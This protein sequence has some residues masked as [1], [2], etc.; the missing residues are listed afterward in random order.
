[1]L[2]RQHA[3]TLLWALALL[4]CPARL[5]A[6]VVVTVP[7]ELHL[8]LASSQFVWYGRLRG[9]ASINAPAV[10][11]EGDDLC[12]SRREDVEN[13][14]VVT[15]RRHLTCD[16]EDSYKRLDN[17]GA[18][19]FITIRDATVLGRE[20]FRR[21]SFNSRRALIMGEVLAM[22]FFDEKY[23]YDTG[24]KHGRGL[25]THSSAREKRFNR[26]ID[27]WKSAADAGELH[28]I[29]RAPFDTRKRRRNLRCSFS[30]CPPCC[31]NQARSLARPSS[32][33][34]LLRIYSFQLTN[35]LHI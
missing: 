35:L 1:M 3:S 34:L 26:Y 25:L 2:P 16:M 4:L 27:D 28:I 7:L 18:L 33:L 13:K 19:A 10:V 8:H 30:S 23:G 15:V 24:K 6:E 12:E 5:P 31:M 20:C 29:V 9:D 22:D 14:V 32:L 11:L 21:M 17:F